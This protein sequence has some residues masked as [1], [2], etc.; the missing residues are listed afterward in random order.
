MAAPSR[1]RDGRRARGSARC[2]RR[3]CPVA[4]RASTC[5][6]A[7]ARSRR[8]RCPTWR[9]TRHGR[10]RSTPTTSRRTPR[11]AASRART[12]L[13]LTYPHMLAFPLH[14]GI[15]T[16]GS[17]PFPAIGT[18][19]LENSITQHRPIAVGERSTSPR[20]PAT[21]ARTPRAGS[22]D[23]RHDGDSRRRDGVGV[24]LDVPAPR[25]RATTSAPSGHAFDR[26]PA[27]R[28][29][30]RLPADLGRRYAAVSGDH[31]P[32]HLYPLTA[33]ALRVPAPDRPRHVD[34][35]PLRR[36]PREP[37]ARRGPRRRRRSRSRSSCPGRCPRVAPV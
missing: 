17:F 35:G 9:C 3:R 24:D 22:F 19:H 31:N 6:P 29:V 7:S 27:G 28:V 37:A 5:S 26:R 33:K 13:P 20:R 10:A 11:S 15:M 8:R 25:A 36:R 30:W 21:C 4:A 23:L 16:D 2:S 12:P 1:S 32:I 18:V 14:M 34:H